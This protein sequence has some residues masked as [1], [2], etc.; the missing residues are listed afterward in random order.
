[1]SVL[2]HS[3]IPQES[4]AHVGVIAL[5]IYLFTAAYSPGEGPVP[6]TVS[7]FSL[8][9]LASAADPSMQYSAEAFPLY[10]RDIGMSM[11]T[12]LLW[13]L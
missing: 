3:F 8:L 11:A 7:V 5:G 4:P 1:M 12:A 13:F 6:F 2:I 10:V 9:G